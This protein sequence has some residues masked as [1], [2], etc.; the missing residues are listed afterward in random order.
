MKTLTLE[1]SDGVVEKLRN[2]GLMTALTKQPEDLDFQAEF[3]MAV[4]KA[5]LKKVPSVRLECPE[6]KR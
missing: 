5:V 2:Y 4:A 3:L 6:P 1:L